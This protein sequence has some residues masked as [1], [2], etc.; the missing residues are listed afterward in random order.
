MKQLEKSDLKIGE[1]Y[2]SN[3]GCVFKYLDSKG[4][5]NPNVRNSFFKGAATIGFGLDNFPETIPEKKHWLKECIKAD[6]FVS[7]EEAMKTFVPEFVLPEIWWVRITK[8][9]LE[10]VC[11]FLGFELSRRVAGSVAGMCK[12]YLTG[13]IEKR[14]NGK[15]T[16]DYGSTF[17]DEITTEQFRKYVLKKQDENISKF[18]ND[19]TVI[20]KEGE[21]FKV[22]DIVK[23][24][25][26]NLKDKIIDFRWKNDKSEICVVLPNIPNGIGID[27]IELYIE[28][29]VEPKQELSLL[30]QVKLKYPVG[31]KYI[32]TLRVLSK[33]TEISNGLFIETPD[34]ILNG[35]NK[36]SIYNKRT[37]K[38]A[39]IVEDF[40]LPEKWCIKDVKEVK[41][42]FE[43][44]N[45]GGY[46]CSNN[47]YLHYPRIGNCC[48]FKT[49]QKDYTEI[50]LEQF[51]KYVLNEKI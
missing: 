28:P 39:E 32:P 8:E 40:V 33:M 22:G 37:G 6:K 36:T 19:K 30:E 14:W 17:G 41:E 3:G 31:T 23:S 48:Y 15:P 29:K 27:K 5:N 47:A 42:F 35:R 45:D 26:S 46:T 43:N 50:T 2:V 9:N 38:W 1:I 13:E 11:K 44:Y 24:I 7:Y 4:S 16:T 12:H 10:D 49:I 20:N 25:N 51:K 34:F 21:V 18:I